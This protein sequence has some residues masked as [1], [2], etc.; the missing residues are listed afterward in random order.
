MNEETNRLV[1]IKEK[2]NFIKTHHFPGCS[3]SKADRST[4][5]SSGLRT[6]MWSVD[7]LCMIKY[8]FKT[9]DDKAV[10]NKWTVSIIVLYF[11]L[12]TFYSLFI[13]IQSFSA[14]MFYHF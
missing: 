14:F 3:C 5:P 6:S 4:R 2:N 11:L 7:N 9:N 8:E 13:Y 1:E 10:Q 12:T